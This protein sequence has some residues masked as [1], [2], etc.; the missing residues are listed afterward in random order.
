MTRLYEAKNGIFGDD[1]KKLEIEA[2]ISDLT[3]R[4]IGVKAQLDSILP[5]LPL[6]SYDSTPQRKDRRSPAPAL[7]GQIIPDD[8]AN[9]ENHGRRDSR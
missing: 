1:K 4:I 9:D 5:T 8:A 6:K 2:S 3:M 7:H